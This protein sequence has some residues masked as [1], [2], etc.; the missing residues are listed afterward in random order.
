M[1]VTKVEFYDG[2]TLLGTDTTSPYSFAWAITSANNGSHSL[3]AKAYDAAANVGTSTPAVGLTINI[4]T[5]DTT[6][7]TVSISAPANG[8]SF[9]TAQ[10]VTINATAADVVGVTRVEFYDG[11][12]LLGTD[13][14]SP[15]SFAWA[16]TSANNGSHSL[17][18]KAYDAAAN[19]GT[20]TAVSVTINIATALNGAT[21][22]ATN[23]EGCHN[24]LA[25]SSKLGRSAS[26]IQT[27]INNNTGGMNFLNTLTTPEIQ[28][29]AAALAPPADTTAPT[30]SISAPANGASF[31]TAQ[32]VTINATAADVVGVTRVEFYDGATL[33]GTDTTSPYS[34]AWAITSASN[35]SHS[36]T[37]KAYDA[38]ANVGTSTAV[39]VT[40]NITGTPPP[41]PSGSDTRAPKIGVFR[42][43]KTA[44]SRQVPIIAFTATDNVGVTGYRVSE[45]LGLSGDDWSSSP[46]LS[47]RFDGGGRKVLYAQV[48][49]AAGNI[50]KARV[51]RVLITLP[52]GG[53]G[54]SDQ[55][56]SGSS[57]FAD[58]VQRVAAYDPI[59]RPVINKDLLKA[60]PVAVGSIAEGGNI[61]SLEVGLGKLKFPVDAYLTLYSPSDSGE[62]VHAYTLNAQNEYEPLVDTKQVWRA[63][64][65][66]LQEVIS[67]TPAAELIPG[68]YMIVFEIKMQGSSELYHSWMT[69]FI[70]Q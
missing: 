44:S 62:P 46:P 3:T 31:T 32:T 9:T 63:G 70:I 66:A 7:P 69:S 37:A 27:A 14:T 60:K 54:D 49:D 38:A 50:S 36:L 34:F 21:L 5:A 33:L 51:A 55:D 12:T 19:V 6:A 61:L 59:S 58:S 23:C 29:I 45:F 52:A 13:T 43:P 15:Y 41:P 47:Y 65:K 4:A 40:I 35:G 11:A 20:S 17:T 1:G 48:R 22:Y 30:V 28:A 42:L 64:V 68:K 53:D 39:S 25:S 67:E 26:Q 2:A 18:A 24:P 8:S 16:I 10:T 57:S 56:S